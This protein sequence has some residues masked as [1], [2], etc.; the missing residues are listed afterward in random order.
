[1]DIEVDHRWRDAQEKITD[2]PQSEA[3]PLATDKVVCEP[4]ASITPAKNRWP[5]AFWCS[6]A[7]AVG[8]ALAVIAAGV[9][10][11][12]ATHRQSRLK[13]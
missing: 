4:T 8:I 11:S 6:I 3:G 2:F 5:S 12:I 7:L 13:S 10:G 9:A 1:M